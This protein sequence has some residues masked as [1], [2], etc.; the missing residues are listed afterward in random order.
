M[1]LP[2]LGGWSS[3]GLCLG[4]Q[5]AAAPHPHGDGISPSLPRSCCDREVENLS[6]LV[7]VVEIAGAPSS[8]GGACP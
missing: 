8:A 2:K 5:L 3:T 4:S 7:C 1:T 6:R